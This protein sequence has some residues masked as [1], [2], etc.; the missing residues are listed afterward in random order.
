[1]AK[2][3]TITINGKPCA[4]TEGE[5]ILA[6]ARRHDI[7]IPTLCHLK[8]VTPTGACRVCM[9]EVEK[10]RSLMAA[11]A[12]P[13]ADGMVVQTESPKVVRSRKMV[14]ELLLSSGRHDC[15]TCAGAGEC[16]LQE[17]AMRYGV[18]G[19]A[20]PPTPPRYEPETANPF[21]M[22]NFSKCILCGRCVQAC[23]DVQV[24]DA[25]HFGYR[26]KRAKIVAGEDVPLQG[27][28]VRLLRRVRAGLPDA[29]ARAQGRQPQ[30]PAL[31][32]AAG[33]HH[34]RLLRRR[35]PALAARE[36]QPDRQGHRRRGD[37]PQPRQPLRQ[38]AVRVRLRR[39]PG[40]ADDAADPRGGGASARPPGTR[41]SASSPR[42]SARRAP[43][44]RGRSACSP[45]RAS[46]TRANYLLQKL[47]RGVLE[48]QQ[49]R[50][51]RPT[52]TQ[53]H[54]GRSGRRVR[55]R[56]DDQPDRRHRGGAG[57][58]RHGLEHH[59]EPPRALLLRQARGQAPGREADRRRPAAHT[60]DP[61]RDALAAAE[62][63]HGRRLDQRPAA[64]DPRRGPRSTRSSWPRGRSG[65]RTCGRSSRSTRRN[66]SRG[67]PA[68]RPPTSSPRRG[69]TPR[70]RPR[71]SS[72]RWGSPS[73][74]P[75]RTTSSRSRTSRC[76]AATSAC[77]A[78]A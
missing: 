22:R 10:A 51:L 37:G 44:A 45:R 59:R 32:G 62:A 18:V 47:A 21:I 30:G 48:D 72:T 69:S 55:L 66:T 40:P 56:G 8:G 60:A 31:G 13:A 68:S 7:D 3:P 76:S 46:A 19:R 33:A 35:L 28:R 75:A 27:R 52:L 63:R 41:R 26:G 5:T 20:F 17:L 4:F 53:L 78:A 14:V 24:N 38:G 43:P 42:S 9:V 71:A 50:P 6:V 16:R 74:S 70:C 54:G 36:G 58:P 61:P 2:Q 73:T 57:A 49:R 67:S 1:M 25:I 23:N 34:L 12:L 39:P 77:A 11:C 29:R 65:S 64:R 15:V